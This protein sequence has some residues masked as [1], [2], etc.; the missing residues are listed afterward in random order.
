MSEASLQEIYRAQ[1][2]EATFRLLSAKVFLSTYAATGALPQL[3]A[4]ILQVR[5]ALEK[6]AFAA[7]APNKNQYIELRAAATNSPDFTM[8]Y[9]ATKILTA[10]GKVNE[11]FYPK[12]L[13]PAK[14]QENGS[15][16]F[17]DK[18]SGF[19]TKKKFKVIY[20]R[21]GKHLHAHNPWSGNKNLQNLAADIPKIIEECHSLL[22][23]HA[24]FIQTPEFQGV[25]VIETD[26]LG[27]PPRVLTAVAH[28]P[29]V[30]DG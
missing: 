28:D 23:L 1:I 19:L 15:W 18:K 22:D 8:D 29:Y 4:T 10:L 25:W 26:R 3:E 7:I 16:H 5:K 9:H 14:K 21:L 12:P 27:N 13:L 17:G 2:A 30:V 6:I 20:D 11:N 24:C